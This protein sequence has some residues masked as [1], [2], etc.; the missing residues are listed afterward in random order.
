MSE[1][2]TTSIDAYAAPQQADIASRAG[3]GNAVATA[4]AGAAM[5]VGAGI[6]T[7]SAAIQR[8]NRHVEAATTAAESVVMHDVSGGR[9]NA[10]RLYRE[11]A[12]TGASFDA[13]DRADMGLLR[14]AAQAE[15]LKRLEHAR[16]RIG[17]LRTRVQAGGSSPVEVESLLQHATE[18]RREVES[19]VSAAATRLARAESAV[20]GEAVRGTLSEMGYRVRE[21]RRTVKDALVVK[22]ESDRGTSIHVWMEPQKGQIRADLSG[23][24]GSACQAERVRFLEGLERRGIR[25]QLTDRESHGRPEG[26]VLAQQSEPLFEDP[27]ETERERRQRALAWH[28]LQNRQGE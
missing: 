27:E 1:I 5:A 12:A 20:L 21:P 10:S 3:L 4:G 25:V 23:F 26:G 9:P 13:L 11:V 17:E 22:G 7:V 6:L 19:I 15:G 18:A 14:A 2:F 16:S 28:Q 8:L 24:R